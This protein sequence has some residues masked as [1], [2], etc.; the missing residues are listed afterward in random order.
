MSDT[1][2]EK[3]NE[4]LYKEG[5]VEWGKRLEPLFVTLRNVRVTRALSVGRPEASISR[6]WTDTADADTQ[7]R[8]EHGGEEATGSVLI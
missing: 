3:V 4:R 6:L 5:S 8:G 7:Q 1:R 2:L